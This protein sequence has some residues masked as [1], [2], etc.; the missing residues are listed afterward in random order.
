MKLNAARR[1]K[2][3]SSEFGLPNK[4]KYPM[5]DRGH[6]ANAKSRATQQYEEGG[7]SLSDLAQV[8]AKANRILRRGR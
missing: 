6:A 7:L 4:R 5:E 8:R 2:I 1:K 3:P